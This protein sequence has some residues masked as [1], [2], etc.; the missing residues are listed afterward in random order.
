M[1]RYVTG[2]SPTLADS[3]R[4]TFYVE[5]ALGCELALMCVALASLAFA[6]YQRRT[7]ARGREAA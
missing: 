1:L 4:D 3:P 7:S 5:L 2:P 6:L